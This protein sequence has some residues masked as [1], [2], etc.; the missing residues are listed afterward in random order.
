MSRL[1]FSNGPEPEIAG[2]IAVYHSTGV[3]LSVVTG[4][5]WLVDALGASALNVV[6][7]DGLGVRRELFCSD[8]WPFVVSSSGATGSGTSP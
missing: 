1:Y 7:R 8:S 6:V 4:L 5:W 2:L 3:V